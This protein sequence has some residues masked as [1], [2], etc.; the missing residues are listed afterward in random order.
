MEY[1]QTGGIL[2]K[3]GE[4]QGYF[5]KKIRTFR[6]FL[7]ITKKKT[8]LFKRKDISKWCNLPLPPFSFSSVSEPLV[9]SKF[10]LVQA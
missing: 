5:E 6:R 10:G 3:N 7:H 1:A 4:D 2:D 9:L 8:L